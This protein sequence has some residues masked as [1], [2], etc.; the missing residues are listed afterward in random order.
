MLTSS[1]CVCV[2]QL[3]W[4]F[5]S[6]GSGVV[7]LVAGLLLYGTGALI[8]LTAYRFGSLSVLQ[9]LLSLNYIATIILGR[10]FLQEEIT[11]FKV[12]GAVC[13]TAGIILIGSSRE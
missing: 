3:F 11:S 10:I 5:Y 1:A 9:P 4:K 12:V 2:G 6:S 7:F 13:I 8:M